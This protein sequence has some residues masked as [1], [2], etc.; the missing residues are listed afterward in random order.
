MS[1]ITSLSTRRASGTAG[2]REAS[3]F[4]GLWINAGVNMPTGDGDETKFVRLPRGI[5]VSDLK[6]RKVY[7]TMDPDFAAEVAIMNTVIAEI[8]AAALD[9]AEG[10]SKEISMDLRLYRRQE[11]AEVIANKDDT[12]SVREALFGA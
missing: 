4:D 10:E 12:A 1:V 11:E 5:A 3:E 8:Q 6:Q 7:E 2:T 9:L